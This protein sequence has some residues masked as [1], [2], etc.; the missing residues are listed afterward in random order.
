MKTTYLNREHMFKRIAKGYE[1]T[2]FRTKDGKIYK[3]F[4]LMNDGMLK[5]KKLK[6]E[7]LNKKDI[8]FITNPTEIIINQKG[9]LTGYIMDELKTSIDPCTLDIN[10]RVEYLIDCSNKL[11]ILKDH[12]ILVL[13]LK[14]D[15]IN[16][17]K[18]G[19]ITFSDSD[20]YKVDDIKEDNV[21]LKTKFCQR[22]FIGND[23]FSKETVDVLF[24]LYSLEIL[25]NRSI[26]NYVA[27]DDINVN[28][29]IQ[30]IN[31]LR[32]KYSLDEND[33]TF[34]LDVFLKH[35]IFS[36]KQYP[37]YIRKLKFR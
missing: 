37:E 33:I 1:G 20:S 13:D 14:D 4:H 25:C 35:N 2:I 3:H 32:E 36:I 15:N 31:Q 11:K 6:L 24:Y 29:I 5:N 26:Y 19:N 28:N 34:L 16:L 27:S 12:N 7:L 18:Y 9:K 10:S 21:S 22:C 23:E 8:P 30:S 17:D